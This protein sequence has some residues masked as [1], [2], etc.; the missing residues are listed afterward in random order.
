MLSRF[1]ALA[2]VIVLVLGT[3]LVGV[4]A[5]VL[6]IVL[7]GIVG[8]LGAVLGAVLILV[9]GTVLGIV[10]ILVIHD[11]F[12]RMIVFAENRRSSL[13]HPSGFILGFENQTDD[14]PGQHCRGD[15]A[16]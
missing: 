10:L 1:C 4:L 8:V 13:P 15:A 7:V 3:V 2:A 5:A 14:E 6:G 16:G 9:L 12:L 11:C